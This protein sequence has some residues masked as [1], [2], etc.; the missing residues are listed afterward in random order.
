MLSGELVSVV[1]PAFNAAAFIEKTLRSVLAQTHKDLEVIIVDDGSTDDTA[2]ICRQLGLA[3]ARVQLV[4]TPNNGVAAARNTGID[5]ASGR[6]IAFIDA[7][8]I[9]HPTKIEK[10]LAALRRLPADWGAVYTLHRFIDPND[11]VIEDDQGFV[12][13]S[14]I[15]GRNLILRPV[16]NGS[17][18]LVRRDAA[19]AINGFDSSYAEIG[20]GGCEDLDFELRLAAKYKIEAIPERL[21]GY[22]RHGAAMSSDRTRMAKAVIAVTEKCL[23]RNPELDGF[24]IRYARASAHGNAIKQLANRRELGLIMR[25]MGVILREDLVFAI[26]FLFDISLNSF[27]KKILA[28]LTD[29]KNKALFRRR[30]KLVDT[31]EL[32][33]GYFDMDPAIGFRRSQ[34]MTLARM[35]LVKLVR[36]DGVLERKRLTFTEQIAEYRLA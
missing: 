2:A 18:L 20:I 23:E 25:S 26:F 19:V 34:R 11:Q 7:D 10:Q 3:D 1:V 32:K 33:I 31:L 12:E 9:W 4:S 29:L 8:D 14:F 13:R 30:A 21:V 28:R 17:S 35:R 36:L 5:R 22:R 6:Y 15:L 16:G 27:P 24:V